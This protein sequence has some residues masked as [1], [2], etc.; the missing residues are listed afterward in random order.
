MRTWLGRAPVWALVGTLC[1]GLACGSA[2]DDA[3]GA[4]SP[5]SDPI[6]TAGSG[7]SGGS[8][9][10]PKAGSGGAPLPPEEEKESS[11]VS[12]TATSNFVWIANPQSGRVA[13]VDPVSLTVKLVDAGNA[14]THLA[15]LPSA[16]G[17]DAA[18]VLNVL[19]KDA[20][21]LRVV[22]DEIETVNVPLPSGGNTWTVSPDGRFAIAWTQASKIP[23][24]DPIDGYQDLTVVDTTKGAV[25]AFPLTVGYRPVAVRF[26]DEVENAYVVTQDGVAVVALAGEPAVTKNVKVAPDGES[27]NTRDVAVTP[28]GSLALVRRDG[29]KGI[30][31]V[32]L[33]DGTKSEVPL[34]APATDLDVTPDGGRAFAV[35]RDTG[36]LAII[37]LTGGPIPTELVKV[38]D[39]KKNVVGSA[40]LAEGAKLAFLYSNAV[41]NPVLTLLDPDAPVPKPVLL[42]APV[43]SVIPTLDAAFAVIVHDKPPTDPT[44]GQPSSKHVAAF[45]LLPVAADLPAK[46]QGLAAKVTSVAVAPTG[47]RAVIATGK[48]GS[49]TW[50][51]F[52]AE[53]PSLKVTEI[54]LASPPTATG[55]VPAKKRAFVA[56]DHPDGR[57]TFIDLA[58]GEV[59]TITG[60]ELASQVVYGGEKK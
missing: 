24:A 58:T 25:K 34:P 38:G 9:G 49:G 32:S 13:F 48:S 56:Q 11:Y 52:V 47:D 4:A 50:S 54:G 28:D 30:T 22:G 16:D 26:D 23:G 12:P 55:I 2:G 1:L 46:I 15:A 43:A 42:R 19:S 39:P 6:P 10:T 36:E 14:P 35:V 20:T 5:N 59:R 8:G 53:M 7:G 31:I 51:A 57:I 21:V 60:F 18:I 41:E 45:S 40:S 3:A 27:A 33:A 29:V 37:H 17:Q 44:T